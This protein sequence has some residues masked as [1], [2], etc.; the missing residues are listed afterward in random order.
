MLIQ[1][2][3]AF[4]SIK[5]ILVSAAKLY[6][7]LERSCCVFL[8]FFS[9]CLAIKSINGSFLITSTAYQIAVSMRLRMKM[10][11]AELDEE[12]REDNRAVN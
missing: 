4:V 7:F 1:E 9:N 11:R 3:A 5:I 2:S 6:D 12:E 10:L 8:F